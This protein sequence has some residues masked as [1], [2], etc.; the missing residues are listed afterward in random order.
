MLRTCIFYQTCFASHIDRPSW[1]P[2][3]RCF[4]CISLSPH[5]GTN[6]F[7]FQ[8]TN[9]SSSTLSNLHSSCTRLFEGIDMDTALESQARPSKSLS[10]NRR[11]IMTWTMWT[12]VARS[13]SWNGMRPTENMFPWWRPQQLLTF[14][15]A[16]HGPAVSFDLHNGSLHMTNFKHTDTC[17]WLNLCSTTQSTSGSF[18]HER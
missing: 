18:Y 15:S 14:C 3:C 10:E 5:N 6:L 16:L 9:L 11:T 17:Q 8:N 2:S 7:K 12:L 4:E 13:S 1:P